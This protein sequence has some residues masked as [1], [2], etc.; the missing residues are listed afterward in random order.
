MEEIKFDNSFQRKGIP[1][2][3]KYIE[4]Q[5]LLG[6]GNIVCTTEV[7]TTKKISKRKVNLSRRVNPFLTRQQFTK[8]Y[9][10][11]REALMMDEKTSID[12]QSCFPNTYFPSLPLFK[13]QRTVDILYVTL[14]VQS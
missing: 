2:Q 3:Q 1:S 10:F 5:V 4:L 6:M 14:Y 11:F 13:L 12:R 7:S 8:R 9:V